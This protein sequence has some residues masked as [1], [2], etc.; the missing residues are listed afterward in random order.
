MSKENK[1]IELSEDDLEK[2]TGGLIDTNLSGMFININ[3]ER[4]GYC[5]YCDEN[6]TLTYVGSAG[7]WIGN[8]LINCN[9][10][11]CTVCNNENY[12]S[13]WDGTLI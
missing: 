2:A 3:T 8:D 4:T 13:V 11:R 1:K 12:Y 7:G 6:R 10:W 5:K 9:L